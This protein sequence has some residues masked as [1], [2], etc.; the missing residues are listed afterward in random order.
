MV[1][2]REMLIV[3]LASC[4]CFC[5]ACASRDRTTSSDLSPHRLGN[6]ERLHV[7]GNIYLASQPAPDDLEQARRRGVKTVINLRRPDELDWDE[8]AKAAELGMAYLS[9][10]FQSPDEMTDET[11]DRLR[12]LL[13]GPHNRPL[14]LH[15]S[16]A[17]RV[18]A[19]W[20]A[21]RVLDEGAIVDAALI[22]ARQV[23]LSRPGH[24]AK[25][26]QYIEKNRSPAV[27]K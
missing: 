17:N 13:R 18:G 16:S 27:E 3:L 15:C 20:W 11:L 9:V 26:R 22:E 12:A 14:L 10:P 5:G 7:R 8:R 1:L 25:T 21:Y 2:K 23:G 6:I 24:E 4:G 19:V